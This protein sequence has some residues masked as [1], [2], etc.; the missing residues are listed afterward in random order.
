MKDLVNQLVGEFSWVSALHAM[1]PNE[2]TE[3]DFERP[4]ILR[5]ANT[6]RGAVFF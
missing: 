2:V 5:T 3:V 4:G 1:Q 6:A